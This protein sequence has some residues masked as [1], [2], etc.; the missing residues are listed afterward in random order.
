MLFKNPALVIGLGLFT[1]LFSLYILFPDLL[2]PYPALEVIL[3]NII[4]FTTAILYG[5]FAGIEEMKNLSVTARTSPIKDALTGLGFMLPFLLLFVFIS[6]IKDTD[7][8]FVFILAGAPILF[9]CVGFLLFGI[10]RLMK[11]I[12]KKLLN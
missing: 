3:P 9:L 2:S 12:T 7:A 10:S 1:I 8:G 4:L 6:T 5:I 11:A